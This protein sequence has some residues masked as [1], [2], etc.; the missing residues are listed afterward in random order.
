MPLKT[1]LIFC[2]VMIPA[3]LFARRAEEKLKKEKAISFSRDVKPLIN[4]YCIT[5]HTAE[6]NHQSELFF[7]SYDTLMKGGGNGPAILPGK[8]KESLLIKKLN[9]PP[10][11]GRVMPPS[12]K[13]K[14]TKQQ[15]KVF[16]DWINQGAKNN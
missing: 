9:S 5:C 6:M 16:Q 12:K 4:T 13:I 7:D 8:A 10:P 3:L 2:F 1:F 11:F 15:I 14:L